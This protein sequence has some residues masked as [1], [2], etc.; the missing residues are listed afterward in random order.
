MDIGVKIIV[1]RLYFLNAPAIRVRERLTKLSELLHGMGDPKRT[2]VRVYPEGTLK[3]GDERIDVGFLDIERRY[4][5]DFYEGTSKNILRLEGIRGGG[6]YLSK[7]D[8]RYLS[9]E[10][11]LKRLRAELP[12]I[13]LFY[14][15]VHDLIERKSFDGDAL[16]DRIKNSKALEEKDEA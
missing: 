12:K 9:V 16:I 6:A 8:L 10:D 4:Y 7:Q 1:A 5:S 3:E 14:D 2:I 15:E 13:K 11:A